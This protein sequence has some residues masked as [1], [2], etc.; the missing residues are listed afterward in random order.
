MPQ[1]KAAKR[2]IER[3]DK[4]ETEG[5]N[6]GDCRHKEDGEC[7]LNSDI[8]WKMKVKDSDRLCIDWDE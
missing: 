6:C 1:S 3:R 7:T 5:H 8:G 2:R 4:L